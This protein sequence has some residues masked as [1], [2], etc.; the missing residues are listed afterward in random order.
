MANDSSVSIYNVR[1]G[2]ISIITATKEFSNLIETELDNERLK[3]ALQNY[4]AGS[5]KFLI[6]NMDS[7]LSNFEQTQHL[8]LLIEAFNFAQQAE[9]ERKS[10]E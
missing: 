7:I 6:E 4:W 10:N 2:L 5:V 8:D 1:G 9:E 3:S